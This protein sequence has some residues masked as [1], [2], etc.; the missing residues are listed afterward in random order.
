M[1]RATLATG[2]KAYRTIYAIAARLEENA[3]IIEQMVRRQWWQR[4]FPQRMAGDDRHNHRFICPNRMA[5]VTTLLWAD[6]L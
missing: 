6:A 4:P 5:P 3:T 2:G 1:V